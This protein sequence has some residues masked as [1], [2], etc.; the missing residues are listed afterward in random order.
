MN[1]ICY[2]SPNDNGTAIIDK[3]T[4]TELSLGGG[5]LHQYIQ[6]QDHLILR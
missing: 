2:I 1:L 4:N 5:Q 6:R 3:V